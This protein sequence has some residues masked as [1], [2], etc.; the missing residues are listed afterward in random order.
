MTPSLE[1]KIAKMVYAIT[2]AEDSPREWN[3]PGDLTGE[4]SAG[5]PTDG[6]MN[7]AGVWKFVNA[8]DGAAALTIKVQRMLTGCSKVYPLSTTMMQ[9]AVKYTGGDN[10][11]SWAYVVCHELGTEANTTLQEYVNS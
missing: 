10:P 9:L 1:L 11:A 7:A 6:T 4:D 5:F 2:K 3:N 8:A